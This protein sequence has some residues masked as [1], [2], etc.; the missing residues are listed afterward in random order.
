MGTV[1]FMTFARANIFF[2]FFTLTLEVSGKMKSLACLILIILVNTITSEKYACP[3][4]DVQFF[5]NDVSSVRTDDWKACGE[6]CSLVCDCEYWTFRDDK[7][8]FLKS[9]DSGLRK[10]E[11]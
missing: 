9:S 1:K 6:V 10:Y 4:Y 2:K 3:E 11:G 8:C 7:S 5:G